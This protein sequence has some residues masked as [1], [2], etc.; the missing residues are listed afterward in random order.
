MELCLNNPFQMSVRGD[1]LPSICS[2]IQKK[3]EF[4]PREG[5][6]ILQIILKLKKNLKYPGGGE[7]GSGLIKNVPQIFSLKSNDT[8]PNQ[9]NNIINDFAISP[10]RM[11]Q[12]ELPTNDLKV[13]SY[14]FS[15]FFILYLIF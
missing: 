10:N 6:S 1:L 3:S 5:V 11:N 7:G 2:Q 15:D 4:D 14:F 12:W 13:E 8:F 9:T